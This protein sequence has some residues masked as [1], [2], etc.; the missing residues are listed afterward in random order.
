V[1]VKVYEAETNLQAWL[2]LDTSASMA[3]GKP[4]RLTKYEYASLLVTSLSTILLRQ[5]DASGLVLFDDHVHQVV[6]TKGQI[7]QLQR[8]CDALEQSSPSGQTRLS[9]G[10]ERLGHLAS[11][12]GVVVVLSDFFGELE[13][14]MRGLRRL[15]A[16]GHD[17][18]VIHTLD[19]DELSFPFEGTVMFEGLEARQ[20]LLVEPRLVR[21]T[22]LREL[23]AH[24]ERVR[25]ACLTGGIRHHLVNTHEPPIVQIRRILSE[26]GGRGR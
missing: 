2:L 9:A 11:R 15:R 13:E 1:Y 12:R 26:P 10:V 24:I 17:V 25:T 16:A 19:G 5:Q 6:P 20:R 14:C 3:Y 23:N 8:L 18:I 21:D 7:S 22:Y 4:E